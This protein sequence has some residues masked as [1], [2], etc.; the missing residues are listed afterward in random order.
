MA[1]NAPAKRSFWELDKDEFLIDE[2][3]APR[4]AKSY[5]KPRPKR[6][7]KAKASTKRDPELIAATWKH[8]RRAQGN[9]R[10]KTTDGHYRFYCNKC[11][12]ATTA[13][14]DAE[15]HLRSRHQI[16]VEQ[17]PELLPRSQEQAEK[18]GGV[19]K[20]EL[21][22]ALLKMITEHKLCNVEWQVMEKLLLT[23]NPR[24]GATFAQSRSEV[25]DIL[26]AAKSLYGLGWD[27]I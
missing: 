13:S 18:V 23:A 4:V 16:D 27:T 5:P 1:P 17:D 3:P 15:R 14:Q 26:G 7:R 10:L 22:A 21:S 19:N 12:W 2:D 20:E 24:I 25:S 6:P 8:F 11:S 9:E